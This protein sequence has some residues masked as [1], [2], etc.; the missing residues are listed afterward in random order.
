MDKFDPV[1]SNREMRKK[2]RGQQDGRP[3]GKQRDKYQHLFSI[4][5]YLHHTSFQLLS[6]LCLSILLA[7]LK[8][9]YM[10]IKVPCFPMVPTSAIAWMTIVQAA[11]SLAKNAALASVVLSAGEFTTH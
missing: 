5:V 10:T 7:S 3:D 6:V 8:A 9:A 4:T 2:M 1:N 11:T